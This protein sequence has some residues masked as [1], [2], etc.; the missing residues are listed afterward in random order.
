VGSGVDTAG[1]TPAPERGP[2][3]DHRVIHTK[4]VGPDH[5]RMY[6]DR[7]FEF[8]LVL[9][10]SIGVDCATR[11]GAHQDAG[12]TFAQRMIYPMGPRR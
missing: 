12:W 6:A 11:G 7:V 1:T 4:A 3:P 10:I 9:V 2:A 8:G 5:G